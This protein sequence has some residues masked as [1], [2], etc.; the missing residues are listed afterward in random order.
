M[1]LK[2]GLEAAESGRLGRHP[3]LLDLFET[4][5]LRLGSEHAPARTPHGEEA[6]AAIAVPVNLHRA[7]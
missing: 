4:S 2:S 7:T 6:V 3:H 5:H 1:E